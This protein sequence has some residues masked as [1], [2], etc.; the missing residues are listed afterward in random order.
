MYLPLHRERDQGPK[1]STDSPEAGGEAGLRDQSPLHV[2]AMSLCPF[3]WGQRQ[4]WEPGHFVAAGVATARDFP[5]S[6]E[7]QLETT[8]GSG[9]DSGPSL[10]LPGGPAWGEQ[11]PQHQ[12]SCLYFPGWA[13]LAIALH[14]LQG[15]EFL[16]SELSLT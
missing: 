10:C 13:V 8:T 7:A 3:Q 6:D 11:Q 15:N 12:A 16:I 14:F 5:H 9:W 1:G 2:D 4:P